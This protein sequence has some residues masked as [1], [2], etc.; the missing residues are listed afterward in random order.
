MF[1][2]FRFLFIILFFLGVQGR[3]LA[4]KIDFIEVVNEQKVLSQSITA[5]YLKL[6]HN[7]NQSECYR[8]REEEIAKFDQNLTLL[9]SNS[10]SD[11]VYE[12]IRDVEKEWK[13]YVK[14]ANWTI[15][16]K[17]VGKIML[18]CDYLLQ[19]CNQLT[20]SYESFANQ[21]INK[22]SKSR[23][24]LDLTIPL[25]LLTKQELLINRILFYYLAIHN[26]I[27]TTNNIV[28]LKR[29]IDVYNTI[30]SKINSLEINSHSIYDNN[31]ESRQYW[32][33]I[34]ST[35]NIPLNST[36][37]ETANI[38][39]VVKRILENIQDTRQLYFKLNQKLSVSKR[40]NLI[41]FQSML[42]QRMSK[43]YTII[44]LFKKIPNKSKQQLITDTKLFEDNI[45]L[46]LY[47]SSGKVN[48]EIKVLKLLW[49]NYKK[50]LLNKKKNETGKVLERNH[51]LMACCD[52]VIKQ[53]EKDA[54]SIN[55]YKTFYLS[56][57]KNNVAFFLYT[58]GKQ[59]SLTQRISTYLIMSTLDQDKNLS[60]K[61]LE[62]A[63]REYQSNFEKLANSELNTAEI[64]KKIS[65][66]INIISTLIEDQEK[67][68]E[69]LYEIIS[70]FDKELD[71]WDELSLYYEQKMDFLMLEKDKK[72]ASSRF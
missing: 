65:T 60:S 43:N 45:D 37:E 15:N 10:P 14:V 58:V 71:F 48:E 9:K 70:S 5:T 13:H 16:N 57:E 33:S 6:Y 51:V 44:S 4:Y 54:Q 26:D 34:E 55:Q 69:R 40:I 31:I 3:L 19:S 12:S 61:R 29:S 22:V 25:N 27:D 23:N 1:F 28:E 62:K 63:I 8:K 50:M 52:R 42:V 72:N 59:R 49:G 47:N 66:E 39:A 41:T 18:E 30:F 46:L 67:S 35:V 36:P 21:T 64:E 20:N 11:K 32:Q 56:E 2:V 17:G 38:L 53:I 68:L 7:I 24:Y